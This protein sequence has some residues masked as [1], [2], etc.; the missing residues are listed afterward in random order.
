MRRAQGIVLNADT[1]ATLEQLAGSRSKPVRL[2][3]RSR[4]IL[5]AAAGMDN[6]AIGAELNISRQKAGRWRSRFAAQGL[7]GIVKEEPRPGRP[8]VYGRRKRAAI[9]RTT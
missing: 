9:V 1:R 3:Q 8:A 2:A 5:L 6:E 4:I 7:D